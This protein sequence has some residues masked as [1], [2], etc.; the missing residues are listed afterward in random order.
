M[1]YNSTTDFLG[2]WRAVAGGVEKVEMPGLDWAVSALLRSGLVNVSVSSIAPVANQ[3][4]TA[5]FQPASPSY[6]AEGALY[7]WNGSAYVA[8]TPRLF[9]EMLA[10]AEK[11][12]A[13]STAI[14]SLMD[15]LS[16]TQGA[17]NF[18]GASAWQS[19][20]PGTLGY[21]LTSGGPGADPTWSTIGSIGGALDGVTN[22]VGAMIYRAGGG[23]TGTG[24]GAQWT[25][26]SNAV[27]NTPSWSTL[28]ALIDGAIGNVRGDVLYRGNANW[29]VLAPGTAGYPLQ[30][31]GA[32]ADPSWAPSFAPYASYTFANIA[33]LA[34]G[35]NTQS[36]P[37]LVS[38]AGLATTISG[39][40]VVIDKTG[41]YLINASGQVLTGTFTNADIAITVTLFVNG[42]TGNVGQ[43]VVAYYSGSSVT[44]SD[45]LSFST[46]RALTA[47]DT[48]GLACFQQ[49]GAAG[50]ASN[51]KMGLVRLA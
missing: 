13:S 5:W 4:T 39:N 51:L 19:L 24:A 8:A 17:I 47:G 2:L 22:T 44:K 11:L 30:T 32:G 1:S 36:A 48:V 40:N 16:T 12:A 23:W 37:T 20:A 45:I 31:G 38:Q 34:D 49:S 25:I 18:R 35:I 46:V 7:L 14:S 15:T 29:S 10:A 9:L 41:T 27:A 21:L 50:S 26:M 28:S 33:S 6:S 43:S 42:S 3:A